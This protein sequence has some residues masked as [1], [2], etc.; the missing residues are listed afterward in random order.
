MINRG[1]Y[2]TKT[3]GGIVAELWV[4]Q[5]TSNIIVCVVECTQCVA[6][7]KV[8]TLN[9]IPMLNT[10]PEQ[11]MAKLGITTQDKYTIMAG[12]W[13]NITHTP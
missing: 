5:D 6:N 13:D 4:T 8:A 12:Y 11:L 3:R 7:D 10:K 1:C 2:D 9:G